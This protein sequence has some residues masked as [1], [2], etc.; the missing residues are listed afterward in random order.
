[1][2]WTEFIKYTGSLYLLY[3]GANILVDLLWPSRARPIEEAHQVLHFSEQVEPV[4]VE[5]PTTST[6]NKKEHV[7]HEAQEELQEET[8]ERDESDTEE[9]TLKQENINS[10]TGG[11]FTMVELNKAAKSEA[12]MYTGHLVY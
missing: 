6:S 10:S 3:Y 4:V 12:V 7:T 5:S 11:I 8:W 9:L 1:M 2:S